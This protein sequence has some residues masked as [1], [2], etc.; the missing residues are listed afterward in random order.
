MLR[1]VGRRLAHRRRTDVPREGNLD[2]GEAVYFEDASQ[3][4]LAVPASVFVMNQ[5]MATPA[6]DELRDVKH[7]WRREHQPTGGR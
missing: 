3:G 6:A 1:Q 7:V 5:T 4:V 2:S